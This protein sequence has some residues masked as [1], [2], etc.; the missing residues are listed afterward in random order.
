MN[1]LQ[2]QHSNWEKCVGWPE[3][4]ASLS[5]FEGMRWEKQDLAWWCW[6]R[7][8][9]I[10]LCQLRAK[11]ETDFGCFVSGLLGE[12]ARKVKNRKPCG[13]CLPGINEPFCPQSK[14]RT[15]PRLR[16]S[17]R[18]LEL[19]RA[20]ESHAAEEESNSIFVRPGNSI[21]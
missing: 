7:V 5:F 1:P 4:P 6:Q 3:G 18:N 17:D 15:P 11:D 14:S 16:R 10:I 9:N 2:S 21:H 12:R 20:K 8:D 19:P 13:S